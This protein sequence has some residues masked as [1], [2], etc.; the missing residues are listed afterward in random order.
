MQSNLLVTLVLL[1]D[2]LVSQGAQLHSKMKSMLV[3]VLVEIFQVYIQEYLIIGYV[4]EIFV[5]QTPKSLG[6]HEGDIHDQDILLLLQ[7]NKKEMHLMQNG[8]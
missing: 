8:M 1:R 4:A 3:I 2:S 6:K 5:T 7:N